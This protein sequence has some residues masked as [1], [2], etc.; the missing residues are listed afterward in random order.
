M[1]IRFLKNFNPV[2]VPNVALRLTLV[3]VSNDL[4]LAAD[5]GL[6][7]ILILLDLSLAFD[8]VDNNVLIS[9]CRMCRHQ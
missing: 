3:K 5:S 9:C 2:S 7:S 8:T 1:K 6:F 4:P